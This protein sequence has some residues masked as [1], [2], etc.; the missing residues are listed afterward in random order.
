MVHVRLRFIDVSVCQPCCRGEVAWHCADAFALLGYT[1]TEEKKCLPSF[2]IRLPLFLR[3]AAT[4]CTSYPFQQPRRL[5]AVPSDHTSGRGML[6]EQSLYM[7]G[8][9]EGRQLVVDFPL[10]ESFSFLSEEK[11]LALFH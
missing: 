2:H 10:T 7:G 9:S 5:V 6:D 11:V 1:S 3:V 8:G 4:P